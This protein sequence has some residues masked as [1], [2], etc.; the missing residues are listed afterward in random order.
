MPAAAG[1]AAIRVRGGFGVNDVDVSFAACFSV[2]H[3]HHRP[4]VTAAPTARTLTCTTVSLL[5]PV[6]LKA[7]HTSLHRTS[8]LPLAAASAVVW[9]TK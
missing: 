1:A 7:S 8:P 2:A 4:V 3:D 5:R 6:V 9:F